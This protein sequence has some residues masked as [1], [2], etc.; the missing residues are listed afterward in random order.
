MKFLS[1]VLTIVFLV[2]Q[3]NGAINWPWY[4]IVS[5]ILIVLGIKVVLWI[6]SL[7]ILLLAAIF[8]KD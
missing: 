5:P 3:I 4:G 1:V 7:I 2:L 8:I 6:I